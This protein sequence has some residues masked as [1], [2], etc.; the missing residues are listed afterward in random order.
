MVEAVGFAPPIR[1]ATC[2]VVI[3]A[4]RET[5]PMSSFFRAIHSRTRSPENL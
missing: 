2:V 4:S 1:A 5:S 3:L